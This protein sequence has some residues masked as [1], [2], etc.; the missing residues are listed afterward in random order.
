MEQG[1]DNLL[2]SKDR[3]LGELVMPVSAPSHRSTPPSKAKTHDTRETAPERGYNHRWRRARLDHLKIHPLCVR[4][5]A[6]GIVKAA[7]VVDHIDPHKGCKGLFWDVSN[8]QSLCKYHHD[9]KTATEDG[10]F[11]R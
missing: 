7:N 4:C 6:K 3:R 8:W 11:G 2:R 9:Q 5:R 1:K 10:G